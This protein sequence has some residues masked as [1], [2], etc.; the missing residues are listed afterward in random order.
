M[1]LALVTRFSKKSFPG[2]GT[3]IFHMFLEPVFWSYFKPGPAGL[4]FEMWGSYRIE[5]DQNFRGFLLAEFRGFLGNQRNS[6]RDRLTSVRD[7]LTGL[8]DCLTGLRDR[9]TGLRDRLTSLRG[10]LTTL[11]GCLTSL[12][13]CLTSLPHL[14]LRK[15]GL[16]CETL[17]L[18]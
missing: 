16:G 17:G 11:R 2:R 1:V 13:H 10:C 3:R 5:T 15:Q 9:L 4:I 6:V 18:G 8:R 14:E 7:R 12:P